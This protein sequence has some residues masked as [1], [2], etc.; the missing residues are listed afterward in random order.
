M[1]QYVLKDGVRKTI[2]DVAVDSDGGHGP[3]GMPNH[4][5]LAPLYANPDTG[6]VF[7]A[8][9]EA[10][11]FGPALGKRL[12]RSGAWQKIGE[13]EV[14]D[15]RSHT[16]LGGKSEPRYKVYEEKSRKESL[17]NRKQKVVS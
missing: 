12:V 14:S 5:A 3:N 9:E 17:A 4:W 2:A 1:T 10:K 15:P 13:V 8:R 16:M 11:S 7:L 6:E